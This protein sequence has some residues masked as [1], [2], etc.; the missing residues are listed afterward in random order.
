MQ[1]LYYFAR[2]LP[3]LKLNAVKNSTID[4]KA[5]IGHG[6]QFVESSIEKYSYIGNGSCIIHTKIGSFC[7]IAAGTII[8]G[9]AHDQF[10]VSTSPVFFKERNILR[11]NF[12]NHTF[13]PYTE[14]TIGNDVWIGSRV[15][16][17]GGVNIGT[18][19]I[20]GMGSIV[21][22]DVPPYAIVGGNPAKIIRYRFSN[23]VIQKLLD[24]EWW[25]W[26]ENDLKERAALFLDPELLID[27]LGKSDSNNDI[28]HK[29]MNN[30]KK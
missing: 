27:Y 10:A 24:S 14:T 22:K 18:G 20:I 11:T 21:T 19:S 9:A 12:A 4:K 26:P 7:S 29:Q 25:N 16:I 3:K 6:T 30:N 15:V 8:G 28:F 17:K 5:S 23:D 2:L 13:P 1:F